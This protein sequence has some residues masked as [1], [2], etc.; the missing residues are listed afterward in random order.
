[1]LN[2]PANRDFSSSSAAG[3]IEATEENEE[4]G[5]EE[6]KEEGPGRRSYHLEHHNNLPGQYECVMFVCLHSTKVT[7]VTEE[8]PLRSFSVDPSEGGV[9]VTPPIKLSL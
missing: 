8:A 9:F 5:E 3:V 6:E 4:D 7:F 1:M 2:Q